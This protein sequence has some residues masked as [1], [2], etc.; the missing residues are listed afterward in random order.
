MQEL[1]GKVAFVTGAASGI[2]FAVARAFGRAN[3]RVML[4]DIEVPAFQS[5]VANLK[6][7]GVARAASNVTWPFVHP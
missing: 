6:S 5:A 2:G 3:M 1:E 7:D 4:A